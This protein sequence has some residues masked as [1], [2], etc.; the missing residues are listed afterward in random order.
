MNDTFVQQVVA[1]IPWFY[2]VMLIEK[3]KNTSERL[4]Y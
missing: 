2:N 1:E 4:W 3:L